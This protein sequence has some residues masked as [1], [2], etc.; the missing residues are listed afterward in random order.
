M[1]ASPPIE[2]GFLLHAVPGVLGR[3]AR[4]GVFL[5]PTMRVVESIRAEPGWF[6]QRLIPQ[7][8][9]DVQRSVRLVAGSLSCYAGSASST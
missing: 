5:C 3:M 4:D 9:P 1:S 6:G 7:A 8:W 2:H